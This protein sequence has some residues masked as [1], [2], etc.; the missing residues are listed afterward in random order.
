MKKVLNNKESKD[1]IDFLKEKYNV[2]ITK[3]DKLERDENIFLIN[4]EAKFFFHETTLVPLLKSIM[5]DNPLKKITVDMGAIPFVVK[6]AD[7]MRP[8]IKKIDEKVAK[9][10]IVAIVD[11]NHGKPLAV[12]ISLFSSEEMQALTS[13]KVV[14]NIHY[15]GDKVW[16]YK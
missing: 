14:K 13:G 7:I 5:V 10:D 15:V 3:K 6:G 16:G 2:D 1:I 11:I 4:N 12:G 8:G 9:G